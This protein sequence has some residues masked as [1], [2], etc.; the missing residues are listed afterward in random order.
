VPGASVRIL[1]PDST[2]ELGACVTDPTGACEVSL[3][4]GRV[5]AYVHTGRFRPRTTA[6]VA[7]E[8]GRVA[9][10]EVSLEA[11]RFL[12]GR[13]RSPDGQPIA[14]AQVGTSDE[15]SLLATTDGEGR[16]ELGGLGEEPINL[17]ATAEGFA[18]KQ[19]RGVRPGSA[20]FDI[21]LER[22]A[23]VVGEVEHGAPTAVRVGICHFDPHFAKELCIARQE[24][25]PT[26]TT[27]R[28]DGL[29]SGNYDVVVEADGFETERKGVRLEADE[30]T[31]APLVTL[32]A[33]V[34]P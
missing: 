12:S 8:S 24:L 18:P 1:L 21:A 29:P 13:V 34:S 4:P 25:E 2:Q 31:T 30:T 5:R 3:R 17:F 11:G 14:G 16:F 10:L 20:G 28:F 15:G 32:R 23:T 26:Q 33:A 22:P 6:P 9:S 19:I 7:I 27:Y